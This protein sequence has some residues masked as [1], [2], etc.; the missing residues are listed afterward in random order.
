MVFPLH[1]R[2]RRERLAQVW[3]QITLFFIEIK[4]AIFAASSLLLNCII[5]N[6]LR[7]LFCDL[8]FAVVDLPL[9]SNDPVKVHA[10]G[11]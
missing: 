8:Q 3:P 4:W 6:H 7:W 10:F 9:N 11:L 5:Y 2:R 1:V